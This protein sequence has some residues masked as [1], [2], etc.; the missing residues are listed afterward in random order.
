MDILASRKILLTNCLVKLFGT[1]AN[2]M[3]IMKIA[4]GVLLRLDCLRRRLDPLDGFLLGMSFFE[5]CFDNYPYII[6]RV[7]CI[8][9]RID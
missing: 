3:R 9:V 8:N 1:W 4:K 5:H 6:H 7:A 2:Y